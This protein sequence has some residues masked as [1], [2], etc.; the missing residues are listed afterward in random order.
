MKKLIGV[1]HLK[2]LPG[3]PQHKDMKYV[4]EHAVKDA[5]ILEKGGVNEIIVENT[6]D[7]P[8]KKVNTAE[9]VAAMTY[10]LSEIKKK[11]GVPLGVCVLWNDYKASLAIT[12]VLDLD[13]VRVP[14]FIEAVLTSSGFIE[15]DPYDVINYR[16]LLR[17]NNIRLLVDVDV[18]HATNM[19]KRSI[20]ESANEALHFGADELVITGKF[21]GDSP[22]LEDLKKV[23]KIS[24]NTIICIGSGTDIEN[25][26]SLAMYADNFIVGTYFKDE[27]GEID[28]EKVKLLR[29]KIES[30][31]K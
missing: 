17:A 1:I 27:K 16:N 4:V 12:K 23:R 2:A 19:S 22:D 10:V 11:V 30:F 7:D 15:G 25:V 13:F 28:V 14:V 29:Q 9:T 20:E 3:Y 5:V 18:K 24:P 31:A 6:D 8:H 26:E 21:T